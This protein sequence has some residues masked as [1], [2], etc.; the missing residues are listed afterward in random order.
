MLRSSPLPPLASSEAAAPLTSLLNVTRGCRYTLL[1]GDATPAVTS[2][3][4]EGG[5]GGGG[6][7]RGTDR[8]RGLASSPT[9]GGVTMDASPPPTIP[10][11][12]FATHS[13]SLPSSGSIV[14]L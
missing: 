1:V 5:G 8:Y 14:G 13:D 6:G 2:G 4:C 7:N 11:G 3:S 9:R 10:I 12:A